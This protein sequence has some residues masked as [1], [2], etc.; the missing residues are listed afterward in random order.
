MW[1]KTL[2]GFVVSLLLNISLLFNIDYLTPIPTE[3][4]LLIGF[5]G[6]FILW[7]SIMS[8]FYCAPSV[9]KPMLYCTPLLI[10][11]AS[12]NTFFYLGAA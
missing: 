1:S 2:L 12:I 3:V 5:I 11:S 9:K 4:F 10:V 8:Y 6:G 7:A